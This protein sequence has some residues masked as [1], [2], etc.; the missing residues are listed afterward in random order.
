MVV[1]LQVKQ[2]ARP[3]LGRQLSRPEL[4]T[5]LAVQVLHSMALKQ[6]RQLAMLHRGMHYVPA[7][8]SV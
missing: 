8:E 7:V 3:Q 5:K 6:T 1:E 4:R 2:R